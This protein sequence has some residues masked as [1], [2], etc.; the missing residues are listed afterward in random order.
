MRGDL[1]T[2]TANNRDTLDVAPVDAHVQSG[3]VAQAL[4]LFLAMAV[5]AL[6][7]ALLYQFPATHTVDIGGYDAAYT[8][9]F[10]DP[11]RLP[12]ERPYLAG[13]D[14]SVRWSRDVS[15]LLFPQA[16]L[17]ARLTLRLRG[18]STTPIE[19]TVSNASQELGRVQVGSEW[20]EQTF[21][22]D[23]GLFK[24]EDV[25]ITLRAPVSPLSE[26]DPRPVGVLLDQAVYTAGGPP[27]LPYPAQVGYGALVA[28]LLYLLVVFRISGSPQH[29]ERRAWLR[30]G[31]G[32]LVLALLFLLL[33]RLQPLYPYPLRGLMPA[34]CGLFAA[35]LLVR[36]GPALA[37][38]LPFLSDAVA[39]GGIALWTAAILVQAQA[40]VVLS[41]PG[42]EKDFRVFA[43][44]PTPA[45]IFKADGF[46]NL[47]YPFL[48]WLVRPFVADNPFLAAQLIGAL[49]GTLLLAATWWLTRTWLGRGP[50]LLALL[51]LALSPLVVQYGLYVGSDMPFA[52]LCTL[53]LALMIRFRTPETRSTWFLIV[54]AGLVAGWAFLVRHPG[55][56]LMLVGWYVLWRAGQQKTRT[57]LVF[58]LVFLLA[59]AP[60]LVVNIRDTG[61]PFYS[62]QAKNIWLAV[63]G[64][65]DWGRWGE[66]SNDITLLQIVLQDPA[67]FLANVWAN[68]RAYAGTGGEDT[69][70]FGRAI[71]L[72]LL[73]FPANWLAVAGL[74]GWL[75]MVLRS[76]AQPTPTAPEAPHPN[77]MPQLLLLWLVLYVLAI[78]VGFALPRFYLPLAPVYA[79]AAAWAITQL[80]RLSGEHWPH[81]QPRAGAGAVGILAGLMLCAVLWNNV[82]T[83]SA[84]VLRLSAA[85]D[86]APGQSA[87]AVAAVQM[88]QQTLQPGEQL[89]VRVPSN[90][91]AGN[92]L[93]YSAI[94][95]LIVPGP[96]EDTIEAIHTT[97]AE[98][99]LWS[100]GLG[101][102]PIAGE[103]LGSAGGYR[104]YRLIQ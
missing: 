100:E 79:I 66:T 86:T 28:G 50:A 6:L 19:V 74:L 102:P 64:D 55:L 84:Y 90:D 4:R 37:Q 15:Y 13:S 59:I 54:A 11:E 83:G 76:P 65:G 51:V 70:E 5:G 96:S 45:E 43:T 80:I 40:H 62:Q 82:A 63:F 101:T 17:P 1:T 85:G 71:Q 32:M 30:W 38:R 48:L 81:I 89:V 94:G 73:G 46:Y 75:L 98:Y 42:V 99:L 47:G 91:E 61:Q 88:V 7:I 33:Y 26:E 24:P 77:T 95:H 22:I 56:V 2:N 14:G 72:R 27:I 36:N 35:L 34:L 58:T 41:I 39:L 68:L 97:G 87:A 104:L 67:R 25:L 49:S 29:T 3:W 92:A 52:A 93:K 9:G 103:P 21:V 57:I 10:Y 78:S 12:S 53:A 60:Q 16:G 23:G 20:T 31:A 44:R 18:H 69:S 8:Q